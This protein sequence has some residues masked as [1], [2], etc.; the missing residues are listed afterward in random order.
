[1]TFLAELLLAKN[2]LQNFKKLD[3]SQYGTSESEPA[4]TWKPASNWKSAVPESPLH[5]RARCTWEPAAP[6]SPLHLS[7]LY[8]RVRCTWEPAAPESLLHLRARCTEE[9]A[10]PESPLHLR[11][12]FTWKPA[13][14]ESLLYLRARCTWE[15]A[16]PES[17]C[18]WEPTAPKSL[19]H[20]RGPVP[21]SALYLKVQCVLGCPLYLMTCCTYL[22]ALGGDGEKLLGFRA[23]EGALQRAHSPVN[24]SAHVATDHLSGQ[25]AVH[26]VNQHT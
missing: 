20:P 2:S 12:R 15:P 8:L 11:A 9:P 10:V 23:P 3:I 26:T 6:K 17:P 19:L 1:M 25:S 21:W 7:P 13:V 5:L 16:V 4:G 22:R 18:T 14:P 24:H